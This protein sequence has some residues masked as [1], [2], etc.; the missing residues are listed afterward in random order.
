MAAFC[1]SVSLFTSALSKLH[2]LIEFKVD[3]ALSNE[4]KR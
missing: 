1:S 2:A 4:Q 3:K